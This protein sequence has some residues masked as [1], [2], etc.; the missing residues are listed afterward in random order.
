MLMALMFLLQ[1]AQIVEPYTFREDQGQTTKVVLKNGLT[2]IVNEQQAV[3]LASITTYV[4]AGYFDEDDR[5]SGIS[6]VIEHMFFKGTSKR[7]VGEIARQTQALGGYLNASTYYDRT[8]YRTEVPAENLKQALEIQ[9]D[10]LWNPVY[11]EN[12]LKKEIEVVLQENNRKLDNPPAVASEKLYEIAFQQHRMKRWRIG[13]PAGLRALTRDDIVAYASKY[14]RPSNI[15]V[16]ISGRV[17]IEETINEVVKLYGNAPANEEPLQRDSGPAEPDQKETRYSWQRGPIEQNHIAL[18]FHA[19]GILSED[20]RALEVLAAILGEGRSSVLTQY[21][22]L[23]R[24]PRIRGSRSVR[25]RFRN[26]QGARSA[27]G[28]SRRNRKRKE[29]RHHERT[30]CPGKSAHRTESL[31]RS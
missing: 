21:V 8:V 6:H 5:I 22:R 10:A 27:N 16:A 2:V 7:K 17:D 20:A 11:D 26:G 18:G 15:I 25:N 28:G 9:A 13:T 14:Y 24:V 30:T 23:C 12:E 31:S 3:P 29:E 19:P 4:K 1:A